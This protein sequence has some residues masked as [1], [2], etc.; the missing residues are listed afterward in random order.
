MTSPARTLL[1]TLRKSIHGWLLG[2]AALAGILSCAERALAPLDQATTPGIVSEPITGVTATTSAGP[3]AA[4]KASASVAVAENVAYV[5]LP[6][7]TIADGES[8]TI[9]NVTAGGRATPPIPMVDGGLDPVPIA[10]RVGD[11]IEVQVLTRGGITIGSFYRVPSRR[12]PRVVRTNP[13]KGRTDVPLNTKIVVVLSEPVTRSSVLNGGVRLEHQ[14][15]AVPGRVELMSGGLL[16]EFIPTAP[17]ARGTTYT[18]RVTRQLRDL[19]GDLSDVE[20]TVTFTTATTDPPPLPPIA[21]VPA[22]AEIAFTRVYNGDVSIYVMSADGSGATRVASGSRAVWSP[23]GSKLAIMHLND[24][25]VLDTDAASPPSRLIGDTSAIKHPAW[26]PDGTKLAYD[27]ERGPGSNNEIF[28][29]NVDGTSRVSFGPG[30]EP[31]W[32]PDGAR[33]AFLMFYGKGVQ[34]GTGSYVYGQK[35]FL[36]GV[37]RRVDTQLTWN[38]STAVTAPVWSPDGARIAFGIVR[39]GRGPGYDRYSTPGEI[40]VIRSDGEGLVNLTNS[41]SHEYGPAWSPDGTKIAFTRTE[42]PAERPQ[43]HVMNADGSGAVNIS[44]NDYEDSFPSWRRRR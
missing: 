31:A 21:A 23:D 22:S 15:Q 35:L 26:S 2:T 27:A 14:G 34:V 12:P 40:Y 25:L 11:E 38:D 29:E 8:V 16:V 33:M 6:A 10:A 30:S 39:L 28:I 44:R 3:A 42:N 17:L 13:P 1:R 41:P 9:R 4:S 7:G 32:A 43:I 18:L 5:S 19:S 20:E 37:E 24:I 36:S